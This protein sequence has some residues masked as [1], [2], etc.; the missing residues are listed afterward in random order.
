MAQHNKVLWAIETI[1][2]I[3]HRCCLNKMHS[4]FNNFRI[5]N[6]LKNLKCN[7]FQMKVILLLIFL[8]IKFIV[9]Q[10]KQPVELNSAI[11]ASRGW[12][13]THNGCNFDPDAHEKL[14]VGNACSFKKYWSIKFCTKSE[15]FNL[16][17]YMLQSKLLR[18]GFRCDFFCPTLKHSTSNQL[19]KWKNIGRIWKY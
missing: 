10:D 12:W 11:K 7:Y 14:V 4:S 9:N 6:A 16:T 1:A 13:Q 19:T 2:P 15:S 8:T 3:N 18:P 5:N 17:Y